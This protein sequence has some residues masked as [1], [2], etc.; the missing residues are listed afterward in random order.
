[1]IDAVDRIEV[2]PMGETASVLPIPT[3]DGVSE[4]LNRCAGIF[5]TLTYRSFRDGTEHLV[6]PARV[7]GESR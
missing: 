5:A 7:P 2:A 3:G 6:Q 1:M 4:P